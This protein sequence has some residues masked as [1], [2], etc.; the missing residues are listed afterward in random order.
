MGALVR[1]E[2]TS[3]AEIVRKLEF[4]LCLLEAA[5][6]NRVDILFERFHYD[7]RQKVICDAAKAGSLE[8]LRFLRAN[9]T[10]IPNEDDEGEGVLYEEWENWETRYGGLSSARASLAKEAK[11]IYGGLQRDR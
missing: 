10:V 8:I 11:W 6:T 3:D 7:V 1:E 9:G 2:S 4:S 5:K